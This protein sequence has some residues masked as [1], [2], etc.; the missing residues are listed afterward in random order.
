MAV[1]KK[2]AQGR[3]RFALPVRIGQVQYGVDVPDE[4]LAEVL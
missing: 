3:V 2:K 4:I 1:D